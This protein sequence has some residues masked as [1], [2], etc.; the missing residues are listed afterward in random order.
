VLARC[1]ESSERARATL[2]CETDIA[3]G[4]GPA[5]RLDAFPAGPGGGPLHVF[6]HG[7]HWQEGGKEESAYPAHGFVSAGAGYVAVGY[8]LAPGHSLADIAAQVR[9]ALL[10]VC[11]HTADLG[12]TPGRVHAGGSSAGAHLV[13]M[14]LCGPHPP[15]LAGVS[16]LSGVYDLEP[17]RNS[18][19][20]DVLRMDEA[21]AR[22]HSPLYRLPATLPDVVLARGEVETGEY[23]RQHAMMAGALRTRGACTD[24]VVAGRNHFDLP[25]DLGRRGT[26][27][28]DA[29]LRQMGLC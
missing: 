13:A 1:R 7:G 16:L 27:L 4:P 25:E 15:P 14:A 8:G 21:T 2:A 29:V 19:V 11:A 28:G 6:V 3:Y 9:R 26:V 22:S 18:Y 20:N 10:W 12:G 17:V 23:R 5:E 24:L